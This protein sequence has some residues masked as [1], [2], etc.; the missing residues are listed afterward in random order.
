MQPWWAS[1]K[2]TNKSQVKGHADED[3]NMCF[4]STNT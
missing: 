4:K 1:Q 3:I 2:S